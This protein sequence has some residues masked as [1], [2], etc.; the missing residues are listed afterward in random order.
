MSIDWKPFVP[1]VQQAR[2]FV[3]TS[4]M[5]PD[6][7]ALGSELGMAA[8]L[9][10]L[11]KTVRIVNGDSVP[12]HISFI[13]RRGQVEVIGSGVTD[14][15]VHMADV[16]MVLDTSAWGQLGPMA[17]VIRSSPARK[18]V[19]DHHVSGDDLGAMT[20][21]DTT[22]ESNGRLV[23]QAVE[24]LGVK[25][26]PDI[27]KP[28]FYAMATDT[29]WFRFSSVTKET[30]VA[31][32]KLVAAGASPHESFGALYD[33]NTLA[34][35]RLHGRI[36]DSAALAIDGRVSVARATDADFAATGAEVAD[37]E[38]VVNRVLSI[39][40]V[41]VAA[42]FVDMGGGAIKV[43]LRS[44]SDF[45]VRQIAELFGGGGHTKAAGVRIRGSVDDAQQ[46]VLEAVRVQMG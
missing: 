32:A 43:S 11:G 38:D 18:V 2:S 3:L 19:I 40:G 37:T 22:S 39:A 27:A 21:K 12:S 30:F 8:A 36:M 24:A 6:C 13:D 4:H 23:L 9:V 35:V 31:A 46:S 16:H 29:G 45:D 10:A 42:L 44:R 20:F 26:T 33:R 15:E 25:L 34:R 7:D 28:L 1:L 5:R 41:E 14:A 17:D